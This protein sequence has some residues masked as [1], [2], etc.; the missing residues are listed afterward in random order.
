MLIHHGFSI[1]WI[2]QNFSD[3]LDKNSIFKALTESRCNFEKYP[4]RFSNWGI[5]LSYYFQANTVLYPIDPA[6]RRQDL[7]LGLVTHIQQKSVSL[8]T[9]A[10]DD[11]KTHDDLCFLYLQNPNFFISCSYGQQNMQKPS[12]EW[13]IKAKL[14]N[15]LPPFNCIQSNENLK[16]LRKL[17]DFQSIYS[18]HISYCRERFSFLQAQK[19]YE[20]NNTP[21]EKIEYVE[22]PLTESALMREILSKSTLELLR[23]EENNGF[24]LR[25]FFSPIKALATNEAEKRLKERMDHYQLEPRKFIPG[26]GNCQFSSLSDQLTN[27]ISHAAFIRRSVVNWLTINSDTVLENGAKIS[28]FSY[29]IPWRAYLQEMSKH[30]TWGDHLTLIAASEIFNKSV[31]IISSIP[32]DSLNYLLEINPNI[33]SKDIAPTGKIMLSHLTEYHY[34]SIQEKK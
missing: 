22:K 27:D 10:I 6:I 4:C 32:C 23:K 21:I 11:N 30:G 14:N 7:L 18:E 16:P 3:K 8:L 1:L 29:D 26:D 17:F 13:F 34:G 24:N 33:Q 5:G 20:E 19:K 28:E 2:I 31:I 12:L 9:Q 15:E 25:E